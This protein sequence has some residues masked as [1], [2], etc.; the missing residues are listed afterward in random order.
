MARR[1]RYAIAGTGSRALGMFARPLTGELAGVGELVGVYDPNQL[2]AAAVSRLAGGVRTYRDFDEM[3]EA[4][5]PD[6]VIVTTVDGFH[7][8]YTIRA[9]RA[10][11]DVISE[12]PMT[13]EASSCRAILGTERETGRRVTVIFN[14]RYDPLASRVRELLRSGAIGRILAADFEWV[15]DRQH[16]ADYFRRWHRRMRSSGG[17]LVHKAT[18]HFDIAN[19][20][21]GEDPDT[22]YAHGARRFYGDDRMPGH[23]KRCLDCPVKGGCELAWDLRS[24]PEAVAL[25]LET[26]AED[27]YLRD[28][29]VFDSSID[30]WD[31]MSV[32]VRYHGGALLTYSLTAYSPSEGWRIAVTGTEGRLET[33]AWSSGPLSGG[34]EEEIRILRPAPRFV[35]ERKSVVETHRVR[36]LAGVHGGADELIRRALF[37][38]DL[39]DPLGRQAGSRAGALSLLIGVAA[40]GSIATGLPVRIP[41]LLA[42]SA[43]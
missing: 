33:E 15:L 32:A 10:G 36:K 9:L 18:H 25:Y 26:E 30:I 2:R 7:H 11:C 17:L 13:T 34:E 43:T 37:R 19:W 5:R 22:V 31:T 41:E 38:G 29:C 39:P 6:T 28:G 24:D 16:G 40:N 1:K 3:L 14:F 23:G 8:E 20:W 27:G 42:G 4:A 21:I 35:T 12:K